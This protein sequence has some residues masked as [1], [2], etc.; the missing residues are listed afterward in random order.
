MT[1]LNLVCKYADDILVSSGGIIVAI[2][3]GM[4]VPAFGVIAFGLAIIAVVVFDPKR[5]G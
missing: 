3:L 4:I 2:G 5:D 1:L